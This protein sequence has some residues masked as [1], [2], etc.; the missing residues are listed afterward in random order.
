MKEPEKEV[1]ETSEEA[2]RPFGQRILGLQIPTARSRRRGQRLWVGT[3]PW[4]CGFLIFQGREK[5]KKGQ[6][7]VLQSYAPQKCA[8][9]T[10]EW[11]PSGIFLGRYLEIQNSRPR[12]DPLNQSL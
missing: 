8:P 10:Q 5:I 2:V 1:R 6:S 12:L 9:S 11:I 7:G 3:S 4:I